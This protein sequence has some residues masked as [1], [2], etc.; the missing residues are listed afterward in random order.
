[1]SIYELIYVLGVILTALAMF[2]RVRDKIKMGHKDWS[3]VE[4]LNNLY[5]AHTSIASLIAITVA[6][7][8]VFLFPVYWAGRAYVYIKEGGE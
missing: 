1:M 2:E 6:V 3:A 7:V 8:A 5:P 4:D